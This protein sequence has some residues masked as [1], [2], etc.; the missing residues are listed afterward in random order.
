MAVHH[1]GSFLGSPHVERRPMLP[2]KERLLIVADN[3]EHF[4]IPYVEKVMLELSG[5]IDHDERQLLLNDAITLREI[6]ERM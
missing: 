3:I 1:D 2:D 6:A 4:Y 5:G